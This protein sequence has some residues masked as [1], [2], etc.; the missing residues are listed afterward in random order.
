MDTNSGQYTSEF[1][2]QIQKSRRDAKARA[3][4]SADE[5]PLSSP[6]KPE[7]LLPFGFHSENSALECRLSDP[8]MGS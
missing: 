1:R 3:F 8:E 4:Q 7:L 5:S 6:Q 2:D